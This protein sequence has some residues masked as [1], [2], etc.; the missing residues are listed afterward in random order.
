MVKRLSLPV[1]AVVAA[2]VTAPVTAMADHPVGIERAKK[3]VRSTLASE[4]TNGG[5]LKP[6]SLSLTCKRDAALVRCGIR[7]KDLRDRRWCGHSSVRPGHTGGEPITI[8]HYNVRM[9]NCASV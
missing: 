7:M 9:A 8:T 2:A 5:G 4:F 3:A 6:G 1:L